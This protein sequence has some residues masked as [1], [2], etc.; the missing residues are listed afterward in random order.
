MVVT[1]D[2]SNET[3]I[4]DKCGGDDGVNIPCTSK[5]SSILLRW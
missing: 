4:D 5:A 1:D 3:D 2:S